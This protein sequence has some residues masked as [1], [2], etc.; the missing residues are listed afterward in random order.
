[1]KTPPIQKLAIMT[2]DAGLAARLS[3]VYNRRGFFLPVLDGP[4]MARP[5]GRSEAVRRNNAIVK[6]GVTKVVVGDLTLEQYEAMSSLFP[7]KSIMALTKNDLDV[8]LRKRPASLVLKW[9]RNNLGVGL[10]TALRENCL[11]EFDDDAD[12]KTVDLKGRK[13]LVVCEAGE[14]LSEIIA[15]NYAFALDADLLIIPKVDR[16]TAEEITEELYSLYDLHGQSATDRL[17]KLSKH[18]RELCP[19]VVVPVGGGV[20]FFTSH[21]P[22]G[23]GFPEAPSTH[24]AIYPDLGVSV[25]NG[26]AAGNAERPGIRSAILVDP[27]EIEAPEVKAVARSLAGRRVFVRAYPWKTANVRDITNTVELFPYDFLLFATHC[28]DADGYRFTYEFNDSSGRARRLVV[29]SAIGVSHT[30]DPNLLRVMLFDRF[31][32]LD[33]V[34]WNDPDKSQKLDVGTAIS[35]FVALTQKKLLEFTAREPIPRVLGSAALKMSDHNYI[36]MPREL[37]DS[38]SPVIFNNACA[39]WHELSGR[40][41]FAGARAYVG[42]LFPVTGVEAAQVAQFFVEQDEGTPLAEALWHA[43]NNAY[44]SSQ[45]RRPYVMTGV[46]PQDLRVCHDDVP[47]YILDRLKTALAKWNS[48]A[49]RTIAEDKDIEEIQGYYQSEIERFKQKW[50]NSKPKAQTKRKKRL[51]RP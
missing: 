34:N 29:D 27:G 11:I 17:A 33:G 36:V 49:S 38:G 23:F 39:S 32:E 8:V 48:R 20:T 14:P 10:L 4:R 47:I 46:Y 50:G 31:Y 6:A 22:Y 9:G 26:F 18:I 45:N 7:P 5:D 19:D 3:C 40:F 41:M 42:T 16:S 12:T 44:G 43:Q 13:H 24:L 2:D 15:A 28:G 30:D 21:I 1:M 35:D 37:A 51:F 25:L